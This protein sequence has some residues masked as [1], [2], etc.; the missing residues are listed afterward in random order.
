MRGRL[1]G[2]VS[3]AKKDRHVVGIGIRRNHI[4]VPVPIEVGCGGRCR[5]IAYAQQRRGHQKSAVTI[6]EEDF[7][8]I[9]STQRYGQVHGSVFVEVS[10]GYIHWI[11]SNRVAF[12]RLESAVSVAEKDQDVVSAVVGYGDVQVGIGVEVLNRQESW[13]VA[14]TII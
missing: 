11:D 13:H 14:G 7:D 4:E 2:F 8:G 6:A 5:S 3:I 10:C 1:E 9:G 12:T